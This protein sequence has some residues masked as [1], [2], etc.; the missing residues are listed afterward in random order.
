MNGQRIGYIRVSSLTK[1]RSTR[2]WCKLR[3]RDAGHVDDSLLPRLSPLVWEHI[4]L[5]SQELIGVR[6]DV[7]TDHA[8]EDQF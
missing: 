4:N 5:M 2:G 7:V 3:L 8:H 6:A 1:T